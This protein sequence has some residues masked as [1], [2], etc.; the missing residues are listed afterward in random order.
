MKP[1]WKGT[2]FFNR[3]SWKVSYVQIVRKILEQMVEVIK[4]ILQEQ[5][6]RM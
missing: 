3:T 2:G 1:L 4:V 6:Q 5:C